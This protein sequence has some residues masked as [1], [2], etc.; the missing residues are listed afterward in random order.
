MAKCC[1]LDRD[2]EWI[3]FQDFDSFL[4]DEDLRRAIE[5]KRERGG[6]R[7]GGGVTEIKRGWKTE[8]LRSRREKAHRDGARK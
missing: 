6:D 7:E 2:N 1:S 3:D 4:E 5:R 8:T